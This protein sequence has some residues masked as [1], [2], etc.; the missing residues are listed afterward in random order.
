[1]FQHFD[2]KLCPLNI[3]KTLLPYPPLCFHWVWTWNDKLHN[4]THLWKFMLS[5]FTN[6]ALQ[7]WTRL[8][9]L[10]PNLV[11]LCQERGGKFNKTSITGMLNV[12]QITLPCTS[13]YTFKCLINFLTGHYLPWIEIWWTGKTIVLA[14]MWTISTGEM[15]FEDLFFLEK[16]KSRRVGSEHALAYE[17][18]PQLLSCLKIEYNAIILK[19]YSQHLM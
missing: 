10:E 3:D 2:W 19:K 17:L 1:M 9:I 6:T 4:I 12:M 7:R 11:R 14:P 5:S 13:P 8:N 18:Q 16:Y 15:N